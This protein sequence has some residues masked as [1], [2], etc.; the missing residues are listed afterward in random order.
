MKEEELIAIEKQLSFPE[1]DSGIEMANMMNETNYTMSKACI[2]SLQISEGNSVLELGH[3]NGGHIQEV[4]NTQK[5]VQYSGLEISST[6][7]EEAQKMNKEFVITK[8]AAFYLYNGLEIPFEQENF[9]KIMTVNTIYFW[10][11]PLQ[12]MNE[13]NRVLK[14]E[15]LF[16]VTYGKA[17][18]LET[19]PFVRNRFQLRS[20][21]EVI[22]LAKRAGFSVHDIQ[23]KSDVVK[24]KHGDI[25]E[26]AFTV[27]V[28]KKN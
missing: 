23:D 6:M 11:E 5:N 27:L 7:K 8:T 3:G 10:R 14:S 25:V 4:I 17:S 18:F 1:G 22:D 21:E 16:S 12:L 13:I 19:L 24:S 2:E 9:D 15:G 20:D 28:L 26:R